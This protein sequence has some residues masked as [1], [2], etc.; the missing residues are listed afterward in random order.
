MKFGLAVGSVGML[1]ATTAHAATI[2]NDVASGTVGY[3]SV[4]V[5]DAGESRTGSITANGQVSGTVTTEVIYDYFTYV[6]IGSGGFRLSGTTTSGA[7]GAG[8]DTVDSAGS[9]T[10]SGGNQIDWSAS[11]SIADGD[12]RMVTTFNFSAATGTLGDITLFQ[13]LDEDVLGVSD[14]VFFTR[15]SVAG[16]SL[17]LFTVDDDELI[18]IS[19]GGAYSDAMGLVNASFEGW[20]ADEYNSMKPRIEAGNQTLSLS[21]VIEPDMVSAGTTSIAG[22]G[23]V[24]GPLDVVSV[25]GWSVSADASSA[26]IITTLGGVPDVTDIPDPDVVPL[27]AAAWLL[28]GGLGALGVAGRRRKA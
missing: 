2:D 21:G 1:M 18:G 26:T 16:E 3:F 10:G 6:D 22:I 7:A 8:D 20:A 15:G 19:H 28:I 14:D 4:D 27:P 13:Y 24:R 25:L 17:E 5:G 9:F 12:S 23:T 11:S